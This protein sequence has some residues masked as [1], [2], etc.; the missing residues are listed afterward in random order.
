[1]SVI[2]RFYDVNAEREWSR[3]AL[4]REPQRWLEFR[5]AMHLLEKYLPPA[6]SPSAT[7]RVDSAEGPVPARVLDVGGGP[8][9]YALA[10][11]E[12]GYRVTLLD[13]SGESLVL[14]RR[15][16]AEAGVLDRIDGFE[17]G[18]ATDLGRF[19]DGSFDSVL[20]MGPLY[21]LVEE[22]DRL[23]AV[24]ESLRVLK[25]GGVVAAAIINH[26]GV[27]RAAATELID[28][29][30]TPDALKIVR[31]YVN[32]APPGNDA[33]FT[34][35]YFAHPL[36]LRRWYEES[37]AETVLLA[38]QEGVAGGLRDACRTLVENRA[39]WQNFVQIVLET[40]E[41]PTLVGGS[42]HTLYIGR[43]TTS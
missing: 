11:A 9:R 31:S 3:L 42:E 34:E 13:L 24:R 27:A 4:E 40:C 22:T 28:W 5:V 1:M 30:S 25:P 17:Q 37:G 10:L 32:I 19:A 7:L 43:K 39:A 35:A 14:A 8:G 18:C 20:I 15:N 2:E 23:A 41:D 33:G 26:L 16:A 38:A 12:R 21:H 29:L 36:E 6:L